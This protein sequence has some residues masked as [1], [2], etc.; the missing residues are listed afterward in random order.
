M[1]DGLG[2]WSEPLVYGAVSVLLWMVP[3]FDRLHVESAAVISLTAFFVAGTAV[4]RRLPGR[5]GRPV[6][7]GVGGS[8]WVQ[9]LTVRIAWLLV[10]ASLLSI[11]AVWAPNCDWVRGAGLFALFTIPT[12][13]FTA[14]MAAFLHARSRRPV[15]WLV[16][17]GVLLTVL[18]PLFDICLHSQFY[19]YSTVFGGVLGPIYD[20]ELV[21]RPGLFVHRVVT[22]AWGLF[23]F[24]SRARFTKWSLLFTLMIGGAYVA[25]GPL[26]LNTPIGYL[27]STFDGHLRTEHFDIHYDSSAT[28]SLE[29]VRLADEHEFRYAQLGRMLDV[30]VDGRISTFIYPDADT[31]ALRTGARVTSV[32]PVWLRTPQIHVE[33]V[34]FFR[35]FPHELV[36]VFS[37]EFG[38][39]I[40]NASIHVGFV[41]GLAVALEPPDGGPSPDEQVAA[42]AWAAS[43]AEDGE[44]AVADRMA[45]ALSA[46]GFWG[47]RG[48][49]SYTTTGSFV[50][51]V[52][53]RYGPAPLKEA[54]PLGDFSAAYDANLEDLTAGWED[55]LQSMT[56]LR[57]TAGPEARR[58]FSL[59]SLF[60]KRCP[61]WVPPH[62]RTLRRASAA[63]RDG[64][65]EEALM[66]VQSLPGDIRRAGSVR[67]F[68]AD[69]LIDDDPEAGL[70]VL[71]DSLI[72]SSPDA[73]ALAGDAL[74]LLGRPIEARDR[75]AGSISLESPD[76]RTERVTRILRRTLAA[77]PEAVRAIR[78]AG[79]DSA[80]VIASGADEWS[81]AS[82]LDTHAE[83]KAA[84][85]ADAVIL[86]Q[87]GQFE[88]AMDRLEAG[89]AVSENLREANLWPTGEVER[90]AQRLDALAAYRSGHFD[91]AAAGAQQAATRYAQ[92]GDAAMAAV[93]ED[94]LE[95]IE[96]RTSAR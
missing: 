28:D 63:A 2:R 18:G 50:G 55:H 87:L 34:T 93:M 14:G 23:F 11:S 42:A 82:A 71:D 24:L 52:F 47:G 46:T 83:R 95:R 60:E 17:T 16:G 76:A 84:A 61:H 57:R 65:S 49:V 77:H 38:L 90:F 59:P 53:D 56:V 31:R 29:L 43:L 9:V 26:G 72:A 39:P 33:R 20:E 79:S 85:I 21:L 44:F 73:A 4:L 54:Y 80:T 41:E 25:S 91:R 67:L 66:L 51:Y 64:H 94:L 13:V 70:R 3:V 36:H 62:V 6:S 88:D 48:A 58:R 96:W 68:E 10:P 1:K 74:A 27:R 81:P 69:L 19:T 32:A 7:G 30:D 40:L 75:Y 22:I 92:V 37:R 12:V 86:Y 89:R 8:R 5:R 35:V 45:S 15:R 78:S